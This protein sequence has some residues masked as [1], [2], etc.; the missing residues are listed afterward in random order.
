MIKS[1]FSKRKFAARDSK[2]R[3]LDK[4]QRIKRA[5]GAD[6]MKVAISP[7]LRSGR[8]VVHTYDLSKSYGG[9]V[10]F[11]NLELVA[12]REQRVGIVGPNGSG[13]STLLKIISGQIEPDS[14]EVEIGHNVQM[15]YFAQDFSHLQ[16]E[17]TVVEELLA[18]ADVTSG[19]ARNLLAQFL[20][21]GEDRHVVVET[22]GLY[23]RGMTVVDERDLR[24]PEPA[25]CHVLMTVDAPAALDLVVAA[26]TR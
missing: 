24:E 20:F 3:Q 8:E 5:G 14:G 11:R 9:Q 12:E 2:Q 7:G 25:N 17:R 26:L 6:V 16:P 23:T 19:E 1:L 13:K 21:T 4:M 22:A 18:D 15:A 10:L